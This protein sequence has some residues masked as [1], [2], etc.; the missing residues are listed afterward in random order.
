LAEALEAK[1]TRCVPRGLAR[2]IAGESSVVLMT[3]IRG[4]SNEKAKR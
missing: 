2:L 4:T 1:P 3:E